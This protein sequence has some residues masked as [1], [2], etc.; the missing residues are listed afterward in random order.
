MSKHTDSK[1]DFSAF[2]ADPEL[3]RKRHISVPPPTQSVK[4]EQRPFGFTPMGGVDIEGQVYRGL[5][6]GRAPWW[7]IL[8]SWVVLG[9]PFFS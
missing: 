9:V 2:D 1:F 8:T 7:V 3:I 5:S 6:R 4:I